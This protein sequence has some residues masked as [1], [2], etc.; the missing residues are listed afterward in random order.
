MTFYI[1]TLIPI[2]FLGCVAGF[3]NGLLGTGG[4]IP[5]IFGL[6]L[7]L[8]RRAADSKRFFTTTLA[9][10]LPLSLY[11]LFKYRA[12][13]PLSRDVFLFTALPAALGGIIGALLFSH[14]S[15]RVLGR[16]FATVVLISGVLAVI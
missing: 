12:V 10:M 4:G 8:K 13:S 6:H 16:I 9:V 11:S 7:L 15:A 3:L 5:L 1:K 2:L 14:L